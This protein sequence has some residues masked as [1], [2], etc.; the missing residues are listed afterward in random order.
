VDNHQVLSEYYNVYLNAVPETKYKSTCRKKGVDSPWFLASS[1]FITDNASDQRTYP[2]QCAFHLHISIPNNKLWKFLHSLFL[3]Q[4]FSLSPFYSSPSILLVSLW[5]TDTLQ[6][7]EGV[8]R[9][10]HAHMPS[11]P[12][13]RRAF[14]S[15]SSSGLVLDRIDSTSPETL[16]NLV[17]LR[18]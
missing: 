7:R 15:V 6:K 5:C 3:P 12:S 17:P 11:R 2:C 4:N 1:I 13:P 8:R 9:R 14:P 18:E 10:P 16:S